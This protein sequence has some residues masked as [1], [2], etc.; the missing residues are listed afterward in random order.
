[1]S[2]FTQYGNAEFWDLTED[3]TMPL[4]WHAPNITVDS[5]QD[6]HYVTTTHYEAMSYEAVAG[7]RTRAQFEAFMAEQAPKI[8]TL[9]GHQ[10]V[11]TITG[12]PRTW[13]DGH[14]KLTCTFT[15]VGGAA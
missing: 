8:N 12:A 1:M 14:C 13:R 10:C 11:M 4:W 7:F 15:K 5:A 2:C 9:D 3:G 6:A